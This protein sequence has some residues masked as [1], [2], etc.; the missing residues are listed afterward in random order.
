MFSKF[1]PSQKECASDAFDPGRSIHSYFAEVARHR[2]DEPAVL[3]GDAALSYSDLDQNS[4][5]LARYLTSRG[6]RP[7][8]IIAF[9][10][11]RSMESI[12]VM[13]GILKAGAAFAPLDPDSP[14]EQL[15]FICSD[16]APVMVVSASSFVSGFQYQAAG[17]AGAASRLPWAAPTILIDSDA[18][19]IA[20]ESKTSLAESVAGDDLAY[21]MYTSGT[22]GQP[23][24]VM[25]PHRGVMR[26]AISRFFNLGGDDVMLQFAPLTFDASTFEIWCALLNGAALAVVAAPHPSFDEIGAAIRKHSVT[27]AWFT[28]SLFHAIVDHQLDILRPLRQLVA[29]GDVLSPRHVRRVLD[30]LPDCRLV[31]GYGPTE[32]TVF[33]CCYEIPHDTSADAAIPIGQPIEHTHIYVLDQELR[34]VAH[35][36]QGELFAAGDGVALGYLNRPD[37]TA[38][39]FL[40]DTFVSEPRRLMYR[41]GDLV[42]RRANGVV[43]FV[44]R[45]DRQ[46]K[47]LGKRVELDEVEGLVRNLPGVRDA[48]AL[49][50]SRTDGTRQIVAYVAAGPSVDALAL[51][52]NMLVT[53]PDHLVPGRFIL[54]A[55]LP[56]T[57]NGKVDR[58]ALLGLEE[59]AKVSPEPTE[60]SNDIEAA[61]AGIWGR[62]LM[63]NSVG[64]DTNFFDL[65]GSSLDVMLLQ[66]EIKA[67]FQR[68]VP[69]TA[70]FEYTTIHS[71]AAHLQGIENAA[72]VRAEPAGEP[73]A[74]GDHHSRRTRQAEALRRASHRRATS[75]S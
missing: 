55:D 12:V 69:M 40:P 4:N 23:K 70:L 49:V 66:Q 52:H 45:A 13:L 41:T 35:G 32:N 31:N 27:T 46:V 71:L 72:R 1:D 7:G 68:D 24:G 62:L 36:E 25:A 8:D 75:A 11:P 43:E 51:R 26:L 30:A 56:R 14:A 67:R 54:L 28:A 10:L 5:Q 2:G 18:P 3:C 16:A 19:S 60:K 6:V 38:D 37:L 21:V 17:S 61:L 20:L 29:G 33:T 34:P 42:R 39:K 50:R 58:S 64:L 63:T 65:G 57:P 53:T 9:L 47:I 73:L 15:A 48:A 74:I 44:G 22:T 59:V